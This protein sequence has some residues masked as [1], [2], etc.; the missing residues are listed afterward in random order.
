MAPQTGYKE[1]QTGATGRGWQNEEKGICW[2]KKRK[3]VRQ[4]TEEGKRKKMDRDRNELALI[5][6]A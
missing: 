4:I 2:L 3:V 1:T 5:T 6:K